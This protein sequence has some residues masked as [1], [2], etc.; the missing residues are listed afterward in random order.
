MSY[1]E[2]EAGH[3]H[4][5]G[6]EVHAH[7][8]DSPL[9]LEL[10]TH[11]PFSVASVA[12][13]LVVA[14]II[15][16]LTPTPATG[17]PEAVPSAAVEDVHDHEHEP[18]DSAG[19]HHHDHDHEPADTAGV[20]EHDHDH[21]SGFRPMFHLFHPLHM[22]FSAAATTAMFWR[23]D[24]KILKAIVVGLVGAIGVCG[25]SDILIPHVSL[26]V[27]GV[28]L[29]IHICVIEHPGMVLPFAVIGIGVG[30]LAAMG[31][32]RS[33]VFSHSM[34]VFVSTMASIFYIIHAFGRLAW[35]DELGYIF[36]F[37]VMAVMVPC[38][39]SDI[40][41]PLAMTRS[42]RAAYART[43]CCQH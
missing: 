21:A 28:H 33:T 20:H 31:V 34:H 1:G 26:L 13:G 18:A 14:G 15:C 32:A 19:V 41:F 37:V 11:L 23:Y 25:V 7:Q 4:H 9:R 40:V 35:I 36:F 10:V 6:H 5:D 43:A 8:P 12:I 22:F 30:L 39:F 29:P 16:F 17:G 38:C 3:V 42:A 2:H 24:R 27:L